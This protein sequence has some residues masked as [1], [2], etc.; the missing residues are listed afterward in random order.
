MIRYEYKKIKGYEQ[1][2]F[3]ENGHTM[4]ETDVLQR[5]KRLAYLEEQIK[6]ANEDKQPAQPHCNI[7]D[8]SPSFLKKALIGRNDPLIKQLQSLALRFRDEYEDQEGFQKLDGVI[9]NLLAL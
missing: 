6:L 9:Y 4:F 2:K 7:A 1:K 3:I 5:L 8:I